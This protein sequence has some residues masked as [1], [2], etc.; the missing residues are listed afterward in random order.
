MQY[1]VVVVCHW[2]CWSQIIYDQLVSKSPIIADITYPA[3]TRQ[4]NPCQPFRESRD[5]LFTYIEHFHLP[6]RLFSES[7]S[8]MRAFKQPIH[9]GMG[10]VEE[11]QT[12]T[13]NIKDPTNGQTWIAILHINQKYITLIDFQLFFAILG[14]CTATAYKN[15][16]CD[17]YYYVSRSIVTRRIYNIQQYNKLMSYYFSR[18]L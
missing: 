14:W 16:R 11:V 6:V 8:S 4:K 3:G 1:I 12:K 17:R 9:D 2:W 13:E 18:I 7:P 5:R 15:R 10:P